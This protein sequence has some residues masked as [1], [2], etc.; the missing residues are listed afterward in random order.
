MLIPLRYADGQSRARTVRYA[1]EREASNCRDPVVSIACG[2]AMAGIHVIGQRC[3]R[4]SLLHPSIHEVNRLTRSTCGGVL[5]DTPAL[6]AAGVASAGT[7]EPPRCIL[8]D[9]SSAV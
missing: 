3:G 4:L 7:S 8:R 1:D 9:Y 6:P 2:A 5:V